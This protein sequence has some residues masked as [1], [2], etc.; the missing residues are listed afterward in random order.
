MEENKD[1]KELEQ[2]IDE[3]RDILADIT[4]GL[5]N[6]KND[7]MADRKSHN[8][9]HTTLITSALRMLKSEPNKEELM[10][11]FELLGVAVRTLEKDCQVTAANRVTDAAQLIIKNS[12][13]MLSYNVRA[14]K[15]N[16]P[17]RYLD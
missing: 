8:S 6:I 3:A 17:K 4:K 13:D 2:A 12:S 9:P 14:A 10:N 7:S 5:R 11:V 1:E 16:F 15:K